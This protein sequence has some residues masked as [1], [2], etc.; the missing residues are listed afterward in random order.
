MDCTPPLLLT[1]VLILSLMSPLDL[2]FET[3]INSSK[4]S[5]YHVRACNL[6]WIFKPPL[7]LPRSLSHVRACTH[8][9]QLLPSSSCE[10]VVGLMEF[11]AG[12]W[13]CWR[14]ARWSWP[15]KE[16]VTCCFFF[17]PSL[18]KIL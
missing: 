18:W 15:L 12:F 14:M 8:T 4:L 13:R 1:Y 11:G 3:S 6:T 16:F 5:L 17:P 10:I 7:T 2:N 9:K